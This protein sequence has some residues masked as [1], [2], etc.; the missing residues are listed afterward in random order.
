[1]FDWNQ[2]VAEDIVTDSSVGLFTM[3][4]TRGIA[5][6]I[7]LELVQHVQ[8]TCV[9]TQEDHGVAMTRLKSSAPYPS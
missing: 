9:Q 2:L 7:S 3:H 5:S 4:M 8:H 6:Y 1:M